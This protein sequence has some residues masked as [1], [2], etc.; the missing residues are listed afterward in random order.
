MVSVTLLAPGIIAA[1]LDDQL[2]QGISLFDLAVDVPVGWKEQ[3]ESLTFSVGDAFVPFLTITPSSSNARFGATS[4]LR[5]KSRVGSWQSLL[6][7]FLSLPPRPRKTM[8]SGNL[9]RLELAFT[10]QTPNKLAA[11]GH[12]SQSESHPNIR[13]FK[14]HLPDPP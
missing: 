3:R 13:F 2:P 7:A 10:T 6:S 4:G 5:L 14:T 11:S 8:I 1:I 12:V 9:S